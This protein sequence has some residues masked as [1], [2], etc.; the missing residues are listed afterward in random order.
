M[1]KAVQTTSAGPPSVMFVGEVARPKPGNGEILI[2]VEATGINRADTLQRKGLYPV[3]AGMSPIMGLE[4]VGK[5]TELGSGVTGW[6]IGDGVMALLSG[7]GYAEYCTVPAIHCIRV[8]RGLEV[9]QSAAIPEVWLTAFQL[10]HLVGNVKKGETVLIHAGGS[11]VGTAAVQLVKLAGA[12]CLVTAGSREKIDLAVKYGAE[13]GANYKE[14]KWN[15]VV[16]EW[17][18]GKGVDVILDCVGGSYAMQNVDCLA[19]DGRWVL[20]GLMGG[21]TVEGPILG[22]LLRKRGALLSTTL[23]TR[24]DQY[25]GELVRQF[26]EKC[27][28]HFEGDSP[29]LK[30]V[31]DCVMNMN[32]IVAAHT[33]MEENKNIGKIILKI[34]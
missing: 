15:E 30:P 12:R 32:Q 28:K 25:K 19:L 11:G 33:R 7:G 13:L 31:V 20:Y 34:A 27:L 26:Q 24:T 6:N 1:M 3:P 14:E 8:P 2:K 21:M 17:T 18:G 16:K 4:A 23:R 5:V 29:K 22:G 9:T 10:L